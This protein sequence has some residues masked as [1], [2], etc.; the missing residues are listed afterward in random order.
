MKLAAHIKSA[1]A[2]RR[3]NAFNVALLPLLLLFAVTSPVAAQGTAASPQTVSLTKVEFEGLQRVTASE[4]LAAAGLSIGQAIDP[5]I[6]D[7]AAERLLNA[8]LFKSLSYR[9]RTLGVQAT[10]IFKVEETSRSVPVVFDNFV[11]F[12]DEELKTAVRRSVPGFDGLAPAGGGVTDTIK[13]VLQDLLHQRGVAGQVEYMPSADAS[14]RN[15]QHVFTVKGA[16]LRV[17]DVHYPGAVGV[18]EALL[19]QKSGAL[20]NNEYS[21]SFVENFVESNLIPIY[22]ERGRL[23]AS[24]LPPKV[25]MQTTGEC[26]G[27]DVSVQIDEG[28]IYLWDKAEWVGNG[29]L[30][31]QELDAALG[32]KASELANTAKIEKGTNA[33]RKAYSRKGFLA[34]QINSSPLFDD[35]GRRAGYRFQID[36]GPQYRMGALF[37]NGLSEQDSNN[38]RG[39]WGLLSK[40]IFDAGYID[41]FAKKNLA[42]FAADLRREGRTF[43]VSKFEGTFKPDHEKRT[44]DVT[45]NFKQ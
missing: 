6:L 17:C 22:H 39:R 35:A 32:M 37:I 3:T 14:G 24:F 18:Q 2:A 8:G 27:L 11:W 10:V 43:D 28:Q 23:R 4:A 29:S 33:V 19:V 16:N 21:R 26:N 5:T 40:E 12:T 25:K 20:F 15:P 36:E 1:V 30:T 7:A 42:E 34:V 44:V 13:S 9:M 41:L 45:L 38:L 31:A